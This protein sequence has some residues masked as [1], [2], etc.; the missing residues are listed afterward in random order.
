[1]SR[2]MNPVDTKRSIE[3]HK[4]DSTPNHAARAT[5]IVLTSSPKTGIPKTIYSDQGSEF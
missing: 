2:Q 4:P 1:M 5:G 3:A